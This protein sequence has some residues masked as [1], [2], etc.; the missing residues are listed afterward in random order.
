M[1]TTTKGKIQIGALLLACIAVILV[2]AF[3]IAGVLA[4]LMPIL[5]GPP[6]VLLG[7]AVTFGLG[8]VLGMAI[9]RATGAL[10]DRGWFR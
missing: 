10:A 6:T 4:V 9:L 3:G 1:K 5:G 8:A 7:G 2:L